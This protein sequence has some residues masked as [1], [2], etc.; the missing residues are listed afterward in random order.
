MSKRSTTNGPKATLMAALAALLLAGT[1]APSIAATSEQERSDKFYREAQE[2]MK[3]RDV[4]AAVIQLK[5]ALKADAGNIAARMLLAEI[6]NR[7]GQ[8]AYA[9]K[10][11]KAAEQRGTPFSDIMVELGKAYL[12]QNRFDDLLKEITLDKATDANRADVLIMRGN[13]E[14]GLRRFDAAEATFREANKAKPD[15]ARSIVGIA[16]TLVSRGR[17][18]DAEQQVDA[19]LKVQPDLVD[20]QVLKAELRR[21]NRDLDSAIDWFSKAIAQRPN[22]VLARLGRAA[23]YI[24]LNRDAE[25]EP[26]LKAVLQAVPRYPMAR[27]LQALSLAKKK[28][29]I[30]AKD[31]LLDAGAALDDHLPSMFLR[32]AVSYALGEYEQAQNQLSRY[33][34]QVPQNVRARKLLGATYVRSNQAAKAIETMKS[35]E[36]QP[37][38]DA[39]SLSLLGSAYMQVGDIGKG[40]EFFEKAAELSPGQAG[41]RTQLAISRLARGQTDKAEEDLEAAVNINKDQTQAGILLTLVRLRKGE[42]DEAVQSAEQLQGSMPGN[43]LPQNLLGAAWLGKGDAV[44]ARQMFEGALKTKP[45]FAP[46]RMNLAQLDLRENKIDA[47]KGEYDTVLKADQKNVGALMG[48]ANI[49]VLEKNEDAAANW[50]NKAAD[51]DPRN[52]APKLRLVALYSE[53]GKPDRALITARDLAL[54]APTNPQ[55]LEI[56]GRTEVANNHPERALDAFE[57]LTDAAPN[58]A[59]AFT[60]LASAQV[61]NNDTAAARTSLK[62]AIELE[63]ASPPARVA[64]IELEV[65]D[66]KFDAALK[67]ADD[68]KKADPSKAIGDMLRGDVLAQQKK[69]DD[70]LKAYDAALKIE[71][72]PVLAIRRYTVQRSAGKTDVAYQTLEKWVAANNNAVARNVLAGAYITDKNY[73]KAI[74]HTLKLLE[75]DQ[76]NPLLLNNLAWSYQQ[77]GDKRAKEYGEKALAAAPKSP[78]VMDTLGWILVQSDDPK[79]G[80]DLLKQAVDAAPNQ[81][82]IRYHM[83]AALRKQGKTD[84]ARK[85]LEKLLAGNESVVNFTLKSDAE[86]MLKELKGG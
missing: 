80:Y 22:H 48:M 5:N 14:L 23:S 67:A 52:V 8:G 72:T 28:D 66:K 38:L 77:T 47:A 9:E 64:L 83:A 31:M 74:E 86:K 54:A 81:G 79:R 43:P 68:L 49:A 25:A 50:L 39:Q 30:G 85:E 46:A 11:L 57:K 3:K 17:I 16:Q 65:K 29:Y 59:R 36:D 44:K 4:N 19:A 13:A 71:D 56:L 33:L 78:A 70:A 42:F 2:Y 61:L 27:Y 32:G 20:A 26:D 1:A 41:I 55:V 7:I 15:D 34:A 6:Y 45:D 40:S 69:Y 18:P 51:V 53:N 10:E 84:D 82:D 58:S 63:P 60:M 24:D 21:L 76:N 35:L 73:P 37:D 62:K 12:Q 75:T